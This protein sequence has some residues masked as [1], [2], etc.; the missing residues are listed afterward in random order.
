MIGSRE[1]WPICGPLHPRS[2]AFSAQPALGERDVPPLGDDEVI[3]D[4]DAHHLPRYARAALEKSETT[5]KE[6]AAALGVS[7]PA[8][9]QALQPG[10]SP[11]L[12]R[13]LVERYGGYTFDGP[14]YRA[15]KL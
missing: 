8:V 10:G 3:V 9:A 14:L 6:A 7:Q 1:A 11:E 5:Q 2:G 12:A 13:Q 15:R 4:R